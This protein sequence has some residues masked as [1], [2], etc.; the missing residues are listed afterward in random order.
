MTWRP[1][2][3]PVK[4]FYG[5]NPQHSY[6]AG[7][8]NG[9]RPSL[10]GSPAFPGRLRRHSR[11][12][13]RQ[14]LGPTC[15]PAP[16]LTPKP[17]PRIPRVTSP[18]AK[19]PAIRPRRERSPATRAMAYPTYSTI[20]A[21]SFRPGRP[22]VQRPATPTKCLTAPQVTALEE[23]LPG[24]AGF[25]R[26]QRFSPASCP[27]QKK[28]PEA[29]VSGSPAPHLAR[30]FFFFG[31]GFFANIVYQQIGL[32]LQNRQPRPGCKPRLTPKRPA[33]S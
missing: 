28:G 32:G 31:T 18:P 4:A 2:K 1:P 9:G 14:F 8:S 11:G 24:R 29:G 30:A 27:E 25:P 20:Q 13:S 22:A 6:F 15:Y 21:V 16:Y 33:I 19:L 10:D 17:P 3:P 23:A 7:C 12:R 26:S 5:N